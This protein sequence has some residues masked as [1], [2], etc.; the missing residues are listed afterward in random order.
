MSSFD[1]FIVL[2][3][4]S[5]GPSTDNEY[6]QVTPPDSVGSEYCQVP[7]SLPALTSSPGTGGQTADFEPGDGR[8]LTPDQHAGNPMGGG[9]DNAPGAVVL[10]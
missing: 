10:T 5:N 4:D 6:P 3:D 9:G 1:P 7:T 2:R 8:V